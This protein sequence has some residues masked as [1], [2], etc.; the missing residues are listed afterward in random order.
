MRDP[1]RCFAFCGCNGHAN[2]WQRLPTW[3]R[4]SGRRDCCAAVDNDDMLCDCCE[5]R[6]QL[7]NTGANV[8]TRGLASQL[9]RHFD[10]NRRR[11]RET[12]AC[13][14]FLTRRVRAHLACL[15]QRAN[16]ARTELIIRRLAMYAPQAPVPCNSRAQ[17][18][19]ERGTDG[20]EEMQFA[21][22]LCARVRGAS[23]T[24]T[25]RLLPW[26]GG[27][28]A[29]IV[30][31]KLFVMTYTSCTERREFLEVNSSQVQSVQWGDLIEVSP[32][33]APG[34]VVP[35]HLQGRLAL[36][37]FILSGEGLPMTEK[38][39]EDLE[40]TLMRC[41]KGALGDRLFGT[42]RRAPNGRRGIHPLVWFQ[43]FSFRYIDARNPGG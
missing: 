34:A 21:L 25:L 35:E 27:C 20:L 8:P 24:L 10:I 18:I 39:F 33:L 37:C 7:H 28:D 9:Q 6:A 22:H 11:L 17:E 5:L 4:N 42:L 23:K 14:D 29:S 16:D 15:V 30:T 32:L 31:G 19:L 2:P 12:A 43:Y 41:Y 40:D 3:L 13:E 26:L 38:G 1:R 36:L